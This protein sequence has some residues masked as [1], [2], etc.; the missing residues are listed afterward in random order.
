MGVTV[1]TLCTFLFETQL[2]LVELDSGLT[3]EQINSSRLSQVLPALPI[4][5]LSEPYALKNKPG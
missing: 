1:A 2:W 5:I 4:I 3:L